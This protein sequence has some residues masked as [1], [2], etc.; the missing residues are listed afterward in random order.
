[1]A[2]NMPKMPKS[3]FGMVLVLFSFSKLNHYQFNLSE[4][5]CHNSFISIIFAV[6]FGIL[7]PII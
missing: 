1:M 3:T 6:I 2:Q 4:A 5:K 7:Y